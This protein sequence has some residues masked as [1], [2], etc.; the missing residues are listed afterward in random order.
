[1]MAAAMAALTGLLAGIFHLPLVFPASD[2]AAFLGVHYLYPLVGAALIGL[3]ALLTSRARRNH[4]LFRTI[5]IGI[6]CYALVLYCHFNVKLWVPHINPARYDDVL[7]MTDQALRPVVDACMDI[8]RLLAG[9]LPYDAN[10]YMTGFILQ[11]YA[12]F[13]Y[14]A[15]RRPEH[16]RELLLAVML[17]QL[18][19]TIGYVMMP[20]LGPFIYESGVNP[21]ISEAQAHMLAFH[22]QSMAQGPAWIGTHGSEAFTAG[23]AAVPS[24][25]AA[26]SALFLAFSRR[27]APALLPFHAFCTLFILIAAVANRWHY[28]IDLPLG[29]LVAALSLSFATRIVRPPNRKPAQTPVSA[30]DLGV[31][32]S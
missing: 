20:A 32:I 7:W 16:F 23:L 26:G 22:R 11:F 2:S 27:H 1:M 21:L 17:M 31:A 15:L 25:H 8:R 6:P 29:L 10:F 14:Y 19:G 28:V 5:L 3:L 4:D 13:A 18:I 24:L 30:A 9:V 12:T